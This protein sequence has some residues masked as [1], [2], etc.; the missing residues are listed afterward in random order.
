[1]SPSDLAGQKR[2]T[3]FEKKIQETPRGVPKIERKHG[4]CLGK[5]KTPLL[6]I[7]KE[8][9]GGCASLVEKSRSGFRDVGPGKEEVGD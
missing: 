8:Y 7:N 9:I 4:L 3:V 5:G 1:L 2:N 6:L